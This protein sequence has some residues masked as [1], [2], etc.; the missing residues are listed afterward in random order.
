MG[1]DMH[2]GTGNTPPVGL[3]R[4]VSRRRYLLLSTRPFAPRHFGHPAEQAIIRTLAEEDGAVGADGDESIAVTGRPLGFFGLQRVAFL[5]AA[6]M[7][8]AG[9][10][11]RAKGTRGSLRGADAGA[12][13]HH[14]L[15]IVAGA[16]GR[17]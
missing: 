3:N 10:I 17:S 14:R 9:V 6:G 8:N 5:L 13:I 11:Q 4:R 15:G 7:G 16:D 1:E 12:E 2:D